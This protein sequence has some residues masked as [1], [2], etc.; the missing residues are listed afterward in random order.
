MKYKIQRTRTSEEGFTLL[1]LIVSFLIIGLVALIIAGAMRLSLNIVEKGEAKI[2]SL[3]RRRT[4]LKIVDSQLQSQFPLALEEDGVTKFYFQ[5]GSKDMRLATNYS[6]WG[7]ERGYVQV[8]YK[9]E[10]DEAGKEMLTASEN[11]IGMENVR[12]A[13]LFRSLDNIYFEYFFK[14][15]T[16]EEGEWADEWSDRF[17][18]PQKI[19]LHLESNGRDFSIIIP[20]RAT[21]DSPK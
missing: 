10:T 19:M 13:T 20:L 14:D 4:S 6:I 1:E 8:R 3:E 12:E 18:L 11:I 21:G 5:G 16:E 15:P 2:D 7:G 9:V 17:K